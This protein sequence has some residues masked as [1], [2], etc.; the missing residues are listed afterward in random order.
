MGDAIDKRS[1]LFVAV[2]ASFLSPF[3]SSSINIALPSIGDEFAVDAIMLGWI[4]TS[5]I[6]VGAMLLVPFGRIGDIYGRKKVFTYGMI[7]FTLSSAFSVFATS[8]DV[9]ILTRVVQGIG[10]AMIFGNSTA[11]ISSVYMPGER[12]KALGI[13]VGSVYLG[14]SMG[15]FLGGVLTGMFGWRSIFIATVLLGIIT[16]FVILWKLKGEW[17]EASG[18]RFDLFGAVVLGIGLLLTMYGF[19]IMPEI[20]GAALVISGILS[21]AFF[22]ILEMRVESPLVNINVFKNNR[23]FVFS[24]IATLINYGATFAVGF[25]L[26]LYLQYIKGLEPEVAGLVLLSQPLV[27]AVFSPIAGRLSDR[28]E[29]RLVASAGMVITTVGLFI[30][31][32]IDENTSLEQILATLLLL[33]FGFSF[34][35]SPNTNAVMNSVEKK[36][37]GV[38]SGTLATMRKTGQMLSMGIAMLIFSLYIGRIQITPQYYPQFL[39]SVN[40]AFAIFTI[41]CFAG[42]FASYARG[43]TPPINGS[44]TKKT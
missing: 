36:F 2:L 34:F 41:A 22:I 15:P 12:G 7:I 23:V 28:I 14:L 19:S 3:M 26:S 43:K 9:L 38:A 40:V 44:V 29:S 39:E 31:I 27:M 5:F 1:V 21:I 30:F 42:I 11:I 37:Y 17:A 4:A 20:L 6:L 33:G 8:T 32:F 13:T 24:N 25:L 35:S 18:E 16:I 10:S